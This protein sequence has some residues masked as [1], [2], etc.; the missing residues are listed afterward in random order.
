MLVAAG[1]IIIGSGEK[2]NMFIMLSSAAVPFLFT[3]YWNFYSVFY[4]KSN[5]S[6]GNYFTF[7]GSGTAGIGVFYHKLIAVPFFLVLFGSVS[8]AIVTSFLAVNRNTEDISLISLGASV[9]YSLVISIYFSKKICN[10]NQKD[11]SMKS[12]NISDDTGFKI[13]FFFAS[14]ATIGLF[15]LVYFI[16]KSARKNKLD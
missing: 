14:I 13:A 15:P 9:V 10:L 8:L 2:D 11:N 12:E 1:L 3:S 16:I 7:K 5:N 6:D 4:E